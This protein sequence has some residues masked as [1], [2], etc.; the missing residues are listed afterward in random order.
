MYG[1]Y[2]KPF[3]SLFAETINNAIILWQDETALKQDPNWIRG[4]GYRGE[5]PVL[6]INGRTRYGAAVMQVAVNNRGKLVFSIQSKAVDAE[7]FRDFLIG[8]RNEYDKERKIIVVCDN[9]S[10]HK[11]KG[12]SSKP[13]SL[14]DGGSSFV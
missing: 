3:V 12:S 11:A 10:I 2:L 5:T 9:A 14:S 13:P 1:L 6:L 7:D 8:I 4:W